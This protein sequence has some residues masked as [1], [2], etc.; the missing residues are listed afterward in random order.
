M[1]FNFF[2]FFYKEIHCYGTLWIQKYKHHLKWLDE[3]TEKI[4][5]K[6]AQLWVNKAFEPQT[7]KSSKAQS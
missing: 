1:S 3:L 6:D 2:F 7:A 5:M 4:F